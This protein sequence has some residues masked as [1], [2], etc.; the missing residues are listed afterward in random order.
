MTAHLIKPVAYLA[1]A[2]AREA[3]RR[4]WSAKAVVILHSPHPLPSDEQGRGDYFIES[5]DTMIHSW[6]SV[7]FT[8]KG[9]RA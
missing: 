5:A 2:E 6:E 1:E 7:I 8:G 9:A 3:A 4:D